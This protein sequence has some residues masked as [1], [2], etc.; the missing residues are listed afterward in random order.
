MASQIIYKSAST[1]KELEQIINLQRENVPE[2]LSVTEMESQGFV[3]VRHT[4][5][6]LMRMNET[7]PHIIAKYNDHVIAYALSMHPDFGN[8]IDVLKPMFAKIHENF[9]YKNYMVMGQ[10]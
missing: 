2:N 4:I 8:T 1:L 3:T 7:L 10:I 9:P 6:L 5:D